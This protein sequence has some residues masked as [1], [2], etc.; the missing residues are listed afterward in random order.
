M[1]ELTSRKRVLFTV[2][3]VLLCA[4]VLESL[5]RVLL[6]LSSP[7]HVEPVVPGSTGQY[8]EQ[9]GW[10]LKPL[11]YAV[12]NRTGYEVEYRINSKG[13]RDDETT[14]DKPHGTF[15]IVLLGDSNTFGFGVPIEKHFSVLLEGYFENLEVINLG[16][17]GFG[18]DQE[19]LRL[20]SE[21]FRYEPDLVLAYVGHYGNHRHMHT[22]RWGKSKPRFVL[23]GAQLVLTNSPVPAPRDGGSADLNTLKRRFWAVRHSALLQTVIG[24][25]W[26]LLRPQASTR[27]PAVYEPTQQRL[28]DDRDAEDEGFTKELHALGEALVYA[29][30]EASRER[31]ATF[32]LITHMTQLHEAA[33]GRDILS[34]DVSRSLAN[35]K[36]ALPDGLG[37]I[38]ESGNGVLAWEIAKFLLRHQLVASKNMN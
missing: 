5:T 21:G 27:T 4:V 7:G 33:L 17:G 11:S 10:S 36:F 3:A 28:Q 13:L 35:R 20:K 37:H 38:N 24:G 32:V 26:R 12:S 16:V 31:G 34:I 19:L 22:R 18:V 1:V 6:L 9:L 14:Y 8:D 2:G 29:M 15:R 25:A 23:D 30:H